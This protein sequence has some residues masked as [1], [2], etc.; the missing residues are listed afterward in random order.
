[1]PNIYILLIKTYINLYVSNNKSL[2][3]FA[4]ETYKLLVNL[5]KTITNFMKYQ[6]NL[7]FINI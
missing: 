5:I 2:L 4:Y 1:M 7:L 6:Q 3:D